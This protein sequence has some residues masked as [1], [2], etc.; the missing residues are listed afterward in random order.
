MAKHPDDKNPKRKPEDSDIHP[1]DEAFDVEENAEVLDADLPA[2]D[3]TPVPKTET[4]RKSM[5]PNRRRRF[6]S[7]RREPPPLGPVMSRTPGDMP[8]PA[9]PNFSLED[10]PP[11]NLLSDHRAESFDVFAR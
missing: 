1:I 4:P 5:R 7:E 6:L 10:A 3:A 9:M 11:P 8:P 2:S